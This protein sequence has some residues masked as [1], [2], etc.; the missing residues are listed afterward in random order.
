MITKYDINISNLSYCSKDFYQIYPEIVDLVKNLTEG[1]YDPEN[2]NE[3]DP[4]IVLLKVAAFLA[5]KIN[6]NIDKN[7]LEV[8]I[9]SAT[10]EDS[11]RKI[12]EMLGYNIKYYNSAETTVSVMWTGEELPEE[13]ELPKN[14]PRYIDLPPFKTVLTNEAK[15]VSY[16]LTGNGITLT[17]RYEAVEAPAMQ[18]ELVDLEIN[19]DNIVLANNIDDNNRLYLPE[20][21]IAENGIWITN[22]SDKKE[23]KRVDNLNTQLKGNPVWKFGY[24]SSRQTPY[25]EFPSDYPSLMQEG[26]QIKYIRT[27]G[28][29]GNIKAGILTKLMNNSVE[30]NIVNEN[31]E[32]PELDIE[33]NLVI[34]NLY[35]TTNG[36]NIETLTEA[37]NG[38]KRTIGT[39]DTLTTCRDYSNAIYAMVIDEKTD[40]TPL[41]S[42]CQVSDIRDE[43]NYAKTVA[44]Y[45]SLGTTYLNVSDQDYVKGK[46]TTSRDVAP[47]DGF[48]LAD[49]IT[50]FDLFLYP[51]NPIKNKYSDVTFNQSFQP[52][53]TTTNLNYTSIL[54]NLEDYKT[55][56]HK[57]NLV[58]DPNDLYLIKNYYDLKGK[59][60][61]RNKVN[62]FEE[63]Q[64][65]ANIYD[66]L[67]R[68]FNARQLEYGEEIPY[69][70]LV[71]VIENSDE[72][73]RTVLLDEPDLSTVYMTANGKE[74]ALKYIASD[75]D[76]KSN[77][78]KYVAKNVLAGK[79]PLFNY[80]T[81][82]QSTFYE[83]NGEDSN[84]YGGENNY[85]QSGEVTKDNSITYISTNYRIN[86]SDISESKPLKLEENEGIQ[87]ICS[88]LVAE[89]TYP[90]YTNYNLVLADTNKK[91]KANTPYQLQDND[92]LYIN[93]T[94]SDKVEYWI[95]YHK[96][97]NEFKKT[98]WKGNVGV[99]NTETFSG[100]I[101]ANV[102]LP[103]KN[104]SPSKSK[105]SD[106]PSSWPIEG[107]YS[108]KTSQEISIMKKNSAKIDQTALVYWLGNNN[109]TL[110]FTNVKDEI[111]ECILND[112]EYFFYTNKAKTD[113]LTLGPGTKLTYHASINEK[114]NSKWPDT[115][116]WALSEAESIT[117]EDVAENGIGAFAQNDWIQKNWN[118]NNYLETEQ[119]E[120]I[121]LGKSV[122]IN[123]LI[124][125]DG[126]SLSSEAWSKL[127]KIEY[128]QNN[129]QN[130]IESV[131]AVKEWSIRS[132]LD[133]NMGPSRNQTLKENQ[134]ITL[135]TSW[136][137][138][139]GESQSYILTD[140]AVKNLL[141]QN[142]ASLVEHI[143]SKSNEL[144]S[145]IHKFEPT[146]GK[147]ITLKSN[148][149]IQKSGGS[150]ISAHTIGLNG[151]TKD[152]LLIYSVDEALP[153]DGN[154]KVLNLNSSISIQTLKDL[155]E[156][157][158]YIELPVYIP[159]N[160]FILVSVYYTAQ[161]G[162]T[163]NVAL[164]Y[165]GSPSTLPVLKE[166][167]TDAAVTEIDAGLHILKI[168]NPAQ[169][170]KLKISTNK[171]SSGSLLILSA[172]LVDCADELTELNKLNKT[173]SSKTI[174]DC[175]GL[176]YKLLGIPASASQEF[177]EI[178]NIKT[179]K[180]NTSVYN[181]YATLDIDNSMLLD[182]T[183]LSDPRSFFNYNNA[184]NK[185]VLSE[186]NTDTFKDIE[187]ASSSKL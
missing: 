21:M 126:T 70:S 57:I 103:I 105:T 55:I 166:W 86:P 117:K 59:I 95:Q 6:Y 63:A 130:T 150:F 151:S 48:Y 114:V 122:E 32:T 76:S 178:S 168:L 44:S 47:Q 73:I 185:F 85:Y 60:I 81:A 87:L 128:I 30:T 29:S 40:N 106:W 137:T 96:E 181:F 165:Q 28:A 4:G 145:Y 90:M 148:L 9:T 41:V 147:E 26:L 36:T 88:K 110:S 184:V 94:D 144:D 153:V 142:P 65:K 139:K 107:L 116:I 115:I 167:K 69:E 179:T 43:L 75:K 102:D 64:I 14:P 78:Y 22:A 97:G 158:N 7:I 83:C 16:V 169:G 53:S 143:K 176:N 186:L 91:I 27:S 182:V 12:C 42:N 121:N 61:T 67:Y 68:N 160:N 46:I 164:T 74:K 170:T 140:E 175:Y 93:Y 187:I 62:K 157:K 180:D 51:L 113:L 111:Y 20:Q 84:V 13:G 124:L 133:L 100:V 138:Q 123:K 80:N 71:S 50:D 72:R 134:S 2:T 173:E 54:A 92:S 155:G 183:N 152:N 58:E 119:M 108:L 52:L 56:S 146:Q 118:K 120:I 49:K 45:S 33:S 98:T 89:V 161:E 127:N 177:L 38:F 129:Q 112:G 25:I 31:N 79:V 104:I 159:E 23:W 77:Y 141:K 125:K 156:N 131:E 174:S 34:K 135:Y 109:N 15:D 101:Q 37:Y 163:L 154:D 39:F 99:S 162:Q 1:A 66:A 19:T 11:F 3:S 10:Q 18:G 136:Y 82:I 149:Y 132:V 8:F 17:H 172:K 35:A 5:D 171:D 24:D